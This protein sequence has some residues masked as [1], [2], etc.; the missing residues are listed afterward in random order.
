MWLSQE[1]YYRCYRGNFE[2]ENYIT[3]EVNIDGIYDDKRG[4]EISHW[5]WFGV[6]GKFGL[7]FQPNLQFKPK[8][9]PMCLIFPPV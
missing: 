8:P 5:T 1:G 2:D 4:N 7:I 6:N 3:H 9:S